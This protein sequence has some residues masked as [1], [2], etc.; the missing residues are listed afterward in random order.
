MINGNIHY[1]C[2]FFAGNILLVN[3]LIAVFNGI[4]SEIDAFATEVL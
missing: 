2:T 4:Y 1:F 3:V